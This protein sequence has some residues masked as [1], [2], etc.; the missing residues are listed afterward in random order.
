[1]ALIGLIN[2]LQIV[3]AFKHLLAI[4]WFKNGR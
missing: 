2:K 4:P 1:M 3:E